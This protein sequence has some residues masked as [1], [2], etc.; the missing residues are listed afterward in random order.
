[1]N[2][3]RPGEQAQAQEAQ[4]E[5]PSSGDDSA[6]VDAFRHTD[7]PDQVQARHRLE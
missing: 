4:E 5:A 7:F 2:G 3:D 6:A 1:L